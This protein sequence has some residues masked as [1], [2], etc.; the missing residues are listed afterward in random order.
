MF[1]VLAHQLNRVLYIS[2]Y[3]E[4]DVSNKL[5]QGQLKTGGAVGYSRNTCLECSTGKQVN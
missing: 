1:Y 2:C 3:S 5:E 4:F